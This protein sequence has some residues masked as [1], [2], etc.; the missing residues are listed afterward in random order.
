MKTF[1]FQKNNR[2]SILECKNA[3]SIEE[4]IS[5]ISDRMDGD[6][7]VIFSNNIYDSIYTFSKTD[8]APL[9]KKISTLDPIYKNL[10]ENICFGF[11]PMK[12]CLLESDLFDNLGFLSGDIC[13]YY[14]LSF[15][16]SMGPVK[17][18]FLSKD[19]VR[20]FLNDILSDPYD[21]GSQI[22]WFDSKTGKEVNFN[23]LNFSAVP[24]NLVTDQP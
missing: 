24:A 23:I 17:G 4:I 11:L 14:K 15:P 18:S 10:A 22:F 16:D 9:K 21:L 3:D 2:N 7:Y 20:K 13:D 1:Y 5:L 8:D 12:H 19:D 6:Q